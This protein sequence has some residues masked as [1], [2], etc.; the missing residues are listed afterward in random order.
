M[1]C[2]LKAHWVACAAVTGA[3]L[4]LLSPLLYDVWPLGLL[5]IYLHSPGYMIHQVE[6]HAGDR[7]RSYVNQRLFG[8]REALTTRGVLWV[9]VGAVW[10]VNLA[11]LYVARWAGPAWALAAPY[12]MIVNAISHIATA[13]R[14][15]GYNP[16][17]LTSLL[18]FLP[19]GVG[20]LW[21]ISATG[22]QHAL[23]LAISLGLHAVIV[24]SVL[25]H[26]R[27]LRD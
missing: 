4:L 15:G 16:G 26:L 12:L 20:S 17:L 5:L 22:A 9:N 11:A 21:R 2:L 25:A 27:Q 19:L 1:Y 23:G 8:G 24:R 18:V 14:F 10:G 6:E 3:A 7:F 13:L